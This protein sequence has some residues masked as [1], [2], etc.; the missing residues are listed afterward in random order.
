MKRLDVMKKTR[1]MFYDGQTLLKHL[2]EEI[3]IDANVDRLASIVDNM[4]DEIES[5]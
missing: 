2:N 3:G 4:N 5:Y 1:K